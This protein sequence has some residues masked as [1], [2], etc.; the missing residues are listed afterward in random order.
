MDA[1]GAEVSS[2]W[3]MWM[4]SA[5]ARSTQEAIVVNLPRL[6]ALGHEEA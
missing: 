4:F 5:F 2:T 1:S 3:S 6:Y